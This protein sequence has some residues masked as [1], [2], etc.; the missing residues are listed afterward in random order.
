MKKRLFAALL[1]LVLMAGQ[2][3]MPVLA[4][5]EPAEGEDITEE[6]T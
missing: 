1:C 6:K 3:G 5:E 4:A 2:V